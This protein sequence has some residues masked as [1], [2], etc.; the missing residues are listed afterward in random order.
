[1][2]DALLFYFVPESPEQQGNIDILLHDVRRILKANGTFICVDPNYLFWLAPW[3]GEEQYPFT[4]F[5]E[6][7]H[8][9]FGVTPSLST[10]VQA[11]GRRGFALVDMQ[12]FQPDPA[13]ESVDRRAYFF[14]R[15]YPLWQ[16]CEW[17][18]IGETGR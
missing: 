18:K 17:K 16:L 12:E 15:E 11:F 2:S 6:Y 8:K 4:I 5:S 10:Y 9:T 14:A 1:M 3:L 7:T 13:F